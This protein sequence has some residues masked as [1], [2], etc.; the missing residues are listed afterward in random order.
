MSGSDGKKPVAVSTGHPAG[1]RAG[2]AEGKPHGA[3]P[4]VWT[5]RMLATLRS[6]VKGG[7]W[8]SL[9]DK[10]YSPTTLRAA[11]DKVSANGGAAPERGAANR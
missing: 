9:I 8:Y 4:A 3:E 5:E 11:F 10:V 6:G 2:E 7:K 1:R